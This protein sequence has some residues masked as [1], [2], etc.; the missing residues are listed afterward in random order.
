[1]K[2]PATFPAVLELRQYTLHPGRRDELIDLFEREFIEPQEAAGIT[3]IGLFRDA[4][5]QDRFV[6]IR[7]FP[8][9]ES[10]RKS[11]ETFYGGPCWKTHRDAANATMIDSDNVLLLRPAG[12]PALSNRLEYRG[13]LVAATYLFKTESDAQAFALASGDLNAAM[14][15]DGGAIVA[16]LTTERSVNTFPRLPVREGEHAVVALFD[17][18]EPERLAL[19]NPAPNEVAD[20]VPAR[21]SD[22]QLARRGLPGDFDFLEGHWNV[23]HRKLRSRLS[24]SNEWIEEAG[25]CRGITLAD[26][27]VS[28]DQFD[29]PLSGIKGCS[30]RNLDREA[31]RWTIHWTTN[32]I[33][34]LLPPVHGGFDN[35]RGEFYGYG[36]ENGTPVFVRYIWSH[37]K[38]GHPR[39][40][41]AFSV[42]GGANW[43]TNWTMD[44]T[45]TETGPQR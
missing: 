22:I 13:P 35:G 5:R 43:E 17:G 39:W 19:Q 23:M 16:L 42:D 9:M 36:V 3:L 12:D 40:E 14:K 15:R 2:S 44:F 1:M 29:F 38:T 27:V 33:G 7:G 25:T 30:L 34:R 45:K 28:A 11:L 31:Q 20:L 8:D 18:I 37:C 41:Q 24:G 32:R 26:G 4:M 6:W 10:R 21:R